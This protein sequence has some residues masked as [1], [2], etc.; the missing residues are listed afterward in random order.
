MVVENL[1]QVVFGERIKPSPYTV[2]FWCCLGEVFDI[3]IYIRTLRRQARSDGMGQGNVCKKMNKIFIL[4]LSIF[5]TSQCIAFSSI[6]S[7]GLYMH[8]IHLYPYCLNFF[9][10]FLKKCILCPFNFHSY[11]HYYT[12]TLPSLSGHDKERIHWVSIY[13]FISAIPH[14]FL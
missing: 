9:P 11:L 4:Y 3:L 12:H 8:N 10:S 2:S 14:P 7:I 6:C 13:L 1:G 5:A